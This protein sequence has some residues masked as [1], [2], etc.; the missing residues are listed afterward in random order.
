MITGMT[1]RRRV[2]ITGM[3]AVSS[4]GTGLA[5]NV[6]ALREGRSGVVRVPEWAEI[7]LASQVAGLPEAEP[8]SP[9]GDRRLQKSV[10]SAGMMALRAAAEALETAGLDP[11]GLRGSPLAVLIGSGTGSTLRNYHSCVA[12]LSNRT[13]KKVSPFT[14]PQVMGSS[15]TAAVSVALG[16]RGE[17]WALSS[18]CST[19]A[20]ALAMAALLVRSGRYERVLAG[21][22]EEV[23]WTRAGAFDA[24]YALSRGFNDRPAEASR[25]FGRDRDG[26]VISGGA[27]LLLVEDLEAAERRGAPIVAELLGSAANSDGHDMVTPLPEGAAEVMRLALEDAGI[28][29]EEVDYVNAHGT[30]T[31]QGDP[32]EAAAMR[33]VFGARQPYLS[34]TKSMTGHAVAAAGSLEAIYTLLML[35]HGFLAPNINVTPDTVDPA[36]GGVRLVLEAPNA[37]AARTAISNSFGFGGTNACL[38]LRR[39]PD[40]D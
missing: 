33:A 38:V 31:P 7:G 15:A 16:A 17:S 26:F 32:S 35:R 34:S 27:G 24:M 37:I 28:A 25:P 14:V 40:A 20:H 6:A 21:A 18:A 11:A 2:V 13:S 30:S 8:A 12:L 5:A 19:G 9:L 23:D 22:A 36:C 29:P 1:S 39:W 4:L 10:S 3:G